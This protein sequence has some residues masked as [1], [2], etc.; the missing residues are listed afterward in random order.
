M[1]SVT[2]TGAI[3]FDTSAADSASA[4]SGG[5]ARAS[6]EYGVHFEDG[7]I[8]CRVDGATVPNTS[9]DL[10]GEDADTA[11]GTTLCVGIFLR[12]LE[13]QASHPDPVGPLTL[14]AVDGNTITFSTDLGTDADK[15]VGALVRGHA[16]VF[17]VTGQ[18]TYEIV[19]IEASDNKTVTLSHAPLL[20]GSFSSSQND[21][22]TLVPRPSASATAVP[23]RVDQSSKNRLVLA[24]GRFT[25]AFAEIAVGSLVTVDDQA[26]LTANGPRSWSVTAVLPQIVVLDTAMDLKDA[27]AGD[28]VNV[29]FRPPRR[30]RFTSVRVPNIFLGQHEARPAVD[31]RGLVYV[32]SFAL[33]PEKMQPSGTCNFSKI[34]NN[35]LEIRLDR[36]DLANLRVYG[37]GYNVLRIENGMAA[38]AYTN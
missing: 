11:A 25:S 27:P 28:A 20:A 37:L 38:V 26:Y 29:R 8:M 24:G 13:E 33:D 34:D 32:Y 35:S 31:N 36:S 14:S 19:S 15:Y 6:T 16:D 1:V 22:V 2:D 18:T 12:S 23:V 17:G 9:V 7:H 3:S 10:S 5:A 4:A 30:R 21:A